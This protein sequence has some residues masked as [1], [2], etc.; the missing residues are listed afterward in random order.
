MA[1]EKGFYTEIVD[2]SA[3]AM[4]EAFDLPHDL[5]QLERKLA[6]SEPGEV[7]MLTN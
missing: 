3:H 5:E 7:V 4:S 2:E 6:E 1:P